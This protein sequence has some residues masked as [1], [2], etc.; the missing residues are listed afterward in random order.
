[1]TNTSNINREHGSNKLENLDVLVHGRSESVSKANAECEE[2]YSCFFSFAESGALA[3]CRM[4][5]TLTTW[6][7]LSSA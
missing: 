1:V 4:W 2:S 3:P 7:R 5:R 6:W